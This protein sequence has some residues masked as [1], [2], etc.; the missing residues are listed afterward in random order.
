MSAERFVDPSKAQSFAFRDL[1]G[2]ASPEVPELFASQAESEAAEPASPDAAA[3][4][5]VEP[6][7]PPEP[8]APVRDP[9]E[10]EREAFEKGFASG[11]RAGMQMA[12][13]KTEAVLKRFA[14][15]LERVGQ[16]REELIGRC[17]K[18]LVALS[19]E[20]AKKLVHREINIDQS[21]IATFV[22]VALEK[23]NVDSRVTVFLNP[24]DCDYLRRNLED[25]FAQGQDIDLTLKAREDI[26]RGDCLIESEY[27]S[28]DARIPEQ[29][30]EIEKGLLG[31][32]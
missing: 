23:L 25:A 11:E 28:I 3:P 5:G 14:K 19:L 17:E 27:G 26:N 8:Q 7:T 21:I 31:S 2:E 32:F 16:L 18:D 13:K 9:H 1:Q 29:F 20:I 22:R 24:I 4:E 15:S 10:I 12:E 30:K 6:E